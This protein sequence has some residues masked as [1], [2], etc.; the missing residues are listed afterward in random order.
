MAALQQA[1]TLSQ[2]GRSGAL[3]VTSTSETKPL[4]CVVSVAGNGRRRH[5]HRMVAVRAAVSGLR[6]FAM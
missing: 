4:P 5:H 3:R 1:A 6:E 2:G